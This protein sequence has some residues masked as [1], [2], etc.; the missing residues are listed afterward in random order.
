M[1]RARI[2]PNGVFLETIEHEAMEKIG[3]LDAAFCEG[4]KSLSI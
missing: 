4:L 3:E 2:V 1:G